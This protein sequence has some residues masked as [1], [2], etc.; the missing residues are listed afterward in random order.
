MKFKFK[1]TDKIVGGFVLTALLTV[2]FIAIIVAINNKVF[3]K[4]YVFKTQFTDAVGLTTTTPIIFKGFEIGRIRSYKLNER[5]MID[6]DFEIYEEY[7]DRIKTNTVLH[8]ARNILGGSTTINLF[9]GEV[10]GKLTEEKGF[11]PSLNT[12]EGNERIEQYKIKMSGDAIASVLANFDNLLYKLTNENNY[13]KSALFKTLDNFSLASEQLVY[14]LTDVEK[15]VKKLE[16]DPQLKGGGTLVSAVQ[17]ISN[18][19]QEAAV[20]IN[21]LNHTLALTD[22]LLLAYKNPDGLVRKM[23]DP[24]GEEIFKPLDKSLQEMAGSLDKL[25]R[26]LSYIDAKTPETLILV[27]EAKATLK[28]TRRTMEGISNNPFIRGGI[29]P[30]RVVEPAGEKVRMNINEVIE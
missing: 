18:L 21:Q 3:V 1:Y 29:T 8:K 16:A 6:A 9:Q 4:K 27:D 17:N 23:V 13:E 11:V 25:N 10:Q 26:L 14:L 28:Q 22:S 12:M 20:T 5:D 19:T 2:V 24:T 30:E 15:I 7:R